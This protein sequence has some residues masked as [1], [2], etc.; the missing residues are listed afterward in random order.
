MRVTVA[1]GCPDSDAGFADV[2][3]SG[4]ALTRC[5][6]DD[7]SAEVIALS[8][9]GRADV[10]L[11]IS[12]NGCGGVSNGH[13]LAGLPPGE[14]VPAGEPAGPAYPALALNTGR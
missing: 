3:N 8:Y 13:I 6:M 1:G 5:P 12:L 7:G 4:P 14:D 2:T 11:W 10:D 9:S